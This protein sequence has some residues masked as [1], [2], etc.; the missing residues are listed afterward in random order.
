MVGRC[1]LT[2]S[3]PVLKAPMVSTLEATIPLS[4]SAYSFNLRRYTV[5]LEDHLRCPGQRADGGVAVGA[6]E[7]LPR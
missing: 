5:G 2:I 3:K 4:N 1:W 6:G 7:R